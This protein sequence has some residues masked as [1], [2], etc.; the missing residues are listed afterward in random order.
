MRDAREQERVVRVVLPIKLIRQLDEALQERLG[1]FETRTEF[2]REAIEN[3]LLELKYEPA[4]PELHPSLK[5]ENGI[6]RDGEA[7]PEISLHHQV[8]GHDSGEAPATHHFSPYSGQPALRDDYSVGVLPSLTATVL[9]APTPGA[10][11]KDGIAQVDNEPLFGLHNRDYPSI[12]AA[13]QLVELTRDG[14]VPL[15]DYLDEVTRRAWSYADALRS[16]EQRLDRKL[17]VMFPRN[18]RKPQS[19]EEGFRAF[20]VGSVTNRGSNDHPSA[21]GPLFAWKVCQLHL[22]GQLL[23]GLTDHGYELLEALDG[24]SLYNPHP[25]E[26]AE[27]FFAHLREH[28]PGDWWG[29][30]TILDAVAEEPDRNALL[31]HFKAAQ[32]DWSDAVVGTNSQGYVG[33]SREWGLI[34][35]KQVKGRYLLTDF[36]RRILENGK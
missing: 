10:I 21:S 20:A 13:H 33:R 23:I 28:A 17:T 15:S 30:E 6:Y 35:P 4:Q 14:L 26:K 16:L 3:M 36:G 2:V 24:I 32:P 7:Q 27:R 9:T 1:G 34:E 5:G 8:D 12:W 25:P 11:I 22:D 19:A 18:F 31:A 29:F